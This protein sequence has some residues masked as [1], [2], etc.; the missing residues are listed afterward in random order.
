[1]NLDQKHRY[2]V[3]VHPEWKGKIDFRP[4]FEPYFTEQSFK[5]PLDFLLIHHLVRGFRAHIYFSSTFITSLPFGPAKRVATIYDLINI[6]LPEYFEGSNRYYAYLARL[7]LRFQTWLTVKNSDR[8]VTIS[9][10]SRRQIVKYY[11]IE[12][13]KV[14]VVYC[15]VGSHLF[16]KP[17]SPATKQRFLIDGPYILGLANFR[18]YKNN[19]VLLQAYAE[20]KKK[21]RKEL[22]VLFGRY[23]K[24]LAE[25]TIM[26]SLGSDFAQ[27]VRLLG[28]LTDDEL[29]EIYT[30]ASVFVFPSLAEGFGIPP[31][32]AMA[33][34]TCVVTSKA[35]SLPEVCGDAA[36][37]VNPRDSIELAS[38]IDTLLESPERRS[39]LGKT[40]IQQARKYDWKDS[41]QKLIKIFETL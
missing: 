21:N 12:Q 33:C 39:F 20:L 5:S 11:G 37:Y 2:L 18:G 6:T 40:G 30:G 34:G 31:I 13:S 38:A 41:V 4:G 16:A 19:R 27:S 23:S 28:P 15:G 26:Q 8:L 22:L 1:M 36:V 32:E 35:G 3:V 14:S 24:E 10:S 7:Y 29:K 17:I 25:L 9:E